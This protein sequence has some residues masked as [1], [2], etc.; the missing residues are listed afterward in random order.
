LHE[1]P[2]VKSREA[3]SD[4]VPPASVPGLACGP[5]QAGFR[6]LAE[7]ISSLIALI[8]GDKLVYVNQAACRLLGC[9]REDLRGRD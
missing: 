5:D 7:T 4:P 6:L 3:V 2:R 9:E 1:D 8:E